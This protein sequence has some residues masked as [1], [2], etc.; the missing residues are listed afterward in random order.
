V[1]GGFTALPTAMRI[2][3]TLGTLMVMLALLV[4]FV[5]FLRMGRAIA[6]GDWPMAARAAGQI[7]LVSGIN[8]ALAIPTILAGVWGIFG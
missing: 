6:A 2:M 8:L 4:F 1:Y 3:V 5:P 7:R